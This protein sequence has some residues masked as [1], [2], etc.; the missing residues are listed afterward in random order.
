MAGGALFIPALILLP[1]IFATLIGVGLFTKDDIIEDKI[2]KIWSS[3]RSK[4]FSDVEYMESL[5]S[6]AGA[7]TLLAIATSRDEGNLFKEERLEEIR[8]RMEQMDF[9]EV[10]QKIGPDQ[11]EEVFTWQDV[12]ATNNV[13]IGTVY[14]FPCVRLSAMDLWVESK[15]YFTELDRVSWYQKVVTDLIINP[16]VGKFGTLVSED[17]QLV[18]GS[19]LYY[20]FSR[21]ESLLLFS[22]LTGM[23]MNDPCKICVDTNY[24]ANMDELTIGAKSFLG[25]MLATV[26]KYNNDTSYDTLLAKISTALASIDRTTI[27]EFTKYYV[28]RSLYAE[29][30]ANSYISAYTNV[31]ALIGGLLPTLTQRAQEMNVSEVTIAQMDLLAHAD[32]PFSSLNTAGNPLPLPGFGG[33]PF[34]GSGMNL[35]GDLLGSIKDLAV[36]DPFDLITLN[37]NP[38][39]WNPVDP[40]S[41]TWQLQVETDPIYQWF[42]GGQDEITAYCGNSVV[43]PFLLSTWCTSYSL[44]LETSPPEE[45]VKTK[46]HFAKMWY[47]LVIASPGFLDI[48]EGVSDPYTYTLGQGCGYTLTGERASYTGK[49]ESEILLAA[50]RDIYFIDEGASLGALDKSLLI[51]GATGGGTTD[52]PYDSISSIQNLYIASKPSGIVERVKNCNRPG[53]TLNITEAEANE[54]LAKFK[55]KMVDVW[56]KGWDDSSDGEVQFTAFFDSV[57]SSGTFNTVLEDISDDS[58]K[59]TVISVVIIAAMSMLFLFN[60]DFVESRMGITFVGIVIVIL[61]FVASLGTAVLIGIKINVN[62]AWTLPFIMIGLGVDDMYIV[63]NAM[64]TRRGNE[65]EDFVEAMNEIISPVTMTSVINASMFA[66]M[67]IIDIGAIYMTSQVAIISVVY[68]YLSIIFCFPAYCYLDMKRQEAKRCDI[69]MCIKGKTKDEPNSS[70]DQDPLSFRIYRGLFLAGTS[71][72]FL[73]RG[74]VILVTLALF[75]A[76]VYGITSRE[77]GVGIEDFFPSTHQAYHWATIRSKDLASWPIMMNWGAIDYTKPENQILMMQ[78]FENVVATTYVTQSDTDR[79]WIVDFNLWTTKQCGSNFDRSDPD[80]KVCGI[81]QFF[82][83]ANA[84]DNGTYCEGTWLENSF[85][86]REMKINNIFI[87][88]DQCS[89]FSGGACYPYTAMF[90]EDIPEGTTN[91]DQKSFCPVTDNWSGEKFK[92]CIERWREFTGG[93]GGLILKDDVTDDSEECPDEVVVEGEIKFPIPLSSSPVLYTEKMFQHKDTVKMIEETREFCDDDPDIHC[94]LT[95][96]PFDYWEQY[97]TVDTTLATLVGTSVAVAF[98]VATAFLFFELNPADDNFTPGKKFIASLV[99]AVII[100]LTIV[101][102]LIPVM[103]ISMLFGVNLTAF[104]NMAFAL[105]IGFA[106]EYSVHVIHRFLAA[107][108]YIEE[109]TKRVE[110]TMKFLTQPLTL[111]FLASVIGVACLAFTEIEFTERF[112]F[113]PLMC[114]MLVTYFVGA[115]FLPIVLTK[116]NFE[117]LRVGHKG[118]HNE[119]TTNDTGKFSD[120][121]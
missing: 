76:G 112:F 81:D 102:C 75:V 40:S 31:N 86:L 63:L 73:L 58:G 38:P 24:E 113:R 109:A 77:I 107:P 21:G 88:A 14:Q 65:K 89:S 119:R 83:D 97:L 22:D 61:S 30:G 28:A 16:R 91:A 94:F 53:G 120:D 78:Q 43:Q 54:I 85:G 25:A 20:R 74:L 79:L 13:G 51:G 42:I 103:G 45:K 121:S 56:S 93:S 115:Y 52:D 116:L 3:E 46:Q 6:T 96:I 57:G 92:F 90:E 108:I 62:M 68:L 32:A 5:G 47:D 98:V 101:T 105:S 19:L 9:L 39:N 4:H 80:V 34:G 17:C 48:V 60:S 12:C 29:L 36:S 7:S 10:K 87:S 49:T 2:Y 111:S 99:G 15:N 117:F 71:I 84:P 100:A 26:Q 37:L 67:Q 8:K 35:S 106:T 118:E 23:R 44:P 59:L 110:Y 72:S 95:G 70:N 18:C 55:I 1:A 64:K 66:V 104:S 50:S 69:F 11:T 114:V 33:A 82:I 41:E 27:E